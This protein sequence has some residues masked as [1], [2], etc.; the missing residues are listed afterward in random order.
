MRVVKRLNPINVNLKTA[1]AK[2]AVTTLALVRMK[3]TMVT[4]I[5]VIKRMSLKMTKMMMTTTMMIMMITTMMT[6]KRKPRLRT[7]M[8]KRKSKIAKTPLSL[9]LLT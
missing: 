9:L 7:M 8:A 6:V 4:R 3:M 1:S 2:S 5:T